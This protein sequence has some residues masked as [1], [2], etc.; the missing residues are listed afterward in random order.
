MSLAN[1]I[2]AVKGGRI[3]VAPR[4]PPRSTMSALN[5]EYLAERNAQM[6]LKRRS[7]EI[8]LAL[9]ES[10][11]LPAGKLKVQLA[12]LIA[13]AREAVRAWHVKLPPQ[14]IGR[15]LHTIG[16]VLRAA[17]EELLNTLAA[18][19]EQLN[20]AGSGNGEVAE[21][22]TIGELEAKERQKESDEHW[23]QIRREKR[24]AKKQTGEK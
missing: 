22:E 20:A 19:P 23:T 12:F 24:A 2:K 14:L 8:D 6:A 18:L 16:Q 1:P 13:A 5:R 3:D 17:E 15:D 10:Q 9:R 21:T 4:L 11:L 7:G